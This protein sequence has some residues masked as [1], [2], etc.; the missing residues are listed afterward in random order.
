MASPG[1][2]GVSPDLAYTFDREDVA[3]A[4]VAARSRGLPVRVV[5]D[6]RQTLTG[7]AEQRRGLQALP[8]RGVQ[9]RLLSG[10][11]L[12]PEYLA[13]GRAGMGGLRGIVHAKGLLL[14]YP[15][16][17]RQ[18]AAAMLLGSSNWTPSS[19]GTHELGNVI[20]WSQSSPQTKEASDYFAGLWENAEPMDQAA[21]SAAQRS[22]SADPRRG[23]F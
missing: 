14:E 4:L 15:P 5:A 12:T 7:A 20:S 1:Q 23:E 9:V 11:P 18:G 19:R 13:A 17:A 2:P 3:S 16:G 6:R 22:K 21:S 10:Y 8:A